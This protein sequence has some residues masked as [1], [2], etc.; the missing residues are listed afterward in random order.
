MK[1]FNKLFACACLTSFAMQLE[2]SH[3]GASGAHVVEVFA[4]G[5]WATCDILFRNAYHQRSALLG[6]LTIHSETRM[7]SY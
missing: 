1:S 5:Y 7:W 4:A 3:E 2:S 6:S